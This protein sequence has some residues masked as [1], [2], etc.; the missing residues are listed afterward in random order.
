MGTDLDE[1]IGVFF[2]ARPMR[3][4][5][6]LLIGIVLAGPTTGRAALLDEAPPSH[7]FADTTAAFVPGE[8]IVMFRDDAGRHATRAAGAS[9]TRL[10]RDPG[11]GALDDLM[12]AHSV[13][14]M[15]RVFRG[16]EDGRGEL[17]ITARERAERWGRRRG[18]PLRSDVLERIPALEN[19]FL[20]QLDPEADV[21]AV[22]A[23]FAQDER[24]VFAHPN[25]LFRIL[26]EPLP[27]VA[28]VPDDP[29]LTRDGVHWS[30][31]AFGQAFPDLWGLRKIRAIEAWNRFD[32]DDSGD[33]GPQEIRPGEGVV[34]AV[35]DSGLDLDHPDVSLAVWTNPDEI[36]DNGIDDDSNGYVD[37]VHGW[38]FVGDDDSPTDENGHG[39][40]V[41]GTI[42]A[43]ADNALGIVGVAPWA[44]IMPIQGLSDRGSGTEADLAAA[45]DYAAAM[46]ARVIS[47][48]WGGNTSGAAMAAAFA[49]AHAFGALAVAAAGNANAS[50]ASLTPASIES[51][52]AVAA[53][54]HEDI[55]AGFSNFGRQ[56]DL[57]APGVRILS[58]NANGGDNRIVDEHPETSVDTDYMVISGTSM[59][60]PHVSGAAAVL[61]SQYPDESA[62]EIRGRLRAGAIDV[63]T[64]NPDFAT[65]LGS[66]RLDLSSS[67]EAVPAPVLWLDHLTVSGF[68]AASTAEISVHVTNYWQDVP[69]VHAELSTNSDDV[70]IVR[71]SADLGD[72][73]IATGASNES[74]PFLVEVGEE[75]VAGSRADFRLSLSGGGTLTQLEFSLSIAFFENVSESSRLPSSALVAWHVVMQDFTADGYP[76][77]GLSNGQS[78]VFFE[79][80]GNGRF[81]R[82]HTQ[83]GG[84]FPNYNQLFLDIDRDGDRDAFLSSLRSNGNRLLRNDGGG[85]WTNITGGSGLPDVRLV[86]MVATD[87][88]DDGWVDIVG[89]GAEPGRTIFLFRN[90]GDASFTDVWEE[91]GLDFRA[92]GSFPSIRMIDYDND[93]DSDLF[94]NALAGGRNRLALYRNDGSGHFENVTAAAFPGGVLDYLKALAAGDYDN[95]GDLDL[96]ANNA[97]PPPDVPTTLY[98][99]NGDGTF[100]DVTESA[101]DLA[102]TDILSLFWG[103]DFFDYDNDGDLDL[104]IT[105]ENSIA[106]E[107]TVPTQS[108]TLFR[109]NGDGTFS[110]VNEAA[111]GDAISPSV[112]TAAIGDYDGDGA[113]DI[114]APASTFLGV[115]PEAGGLLRNL[116]GARNNWIR[117]ELVGDTSNRDAYGAR[118]V[119][120]TR[121][122]SQIRE[123]HTAPVD[124]TGLHFGLG[125]APVIESIEV[126]WPSGIVQQ[127]HGIRVNRRLVIHECR[128]PET[129]PGRRRGQTCAR[130][131]PRSR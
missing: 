31:G 94:A 81:R 61:M 84:P 120:R 13:R 27:A 108:H 59:A 9:F 68:N 104:Y 10:L 54:D 101:G 45:V 12:R 77:V 98:R 92:L 17:R 116:I 41:A 122:G 130:G 23:E 49:N 118:V 72:I 107:D 69:D 73:P 44:Q 110:L 129:L 48:S 35:V 4:V 66:G 42:A 36:P 56:I 24:V 102:N 11:A 125:Q 86:A 55:R 109:N 43:H 57:T 5:N 83:S 121:G 15:R 22:A 30:E 1:R 3:V 2:G 111:F 124:P 21:E 40:H 82:S 85:A 119:V 16:L 62:D 91:S 99:N 20:L 32:T 103:S 50:V 75:A 51:V 88:D 76:D 93:G 34:V 127:L 115:D 131:R 80:L 8:L 65:T 67:L 90:N 29:Y 97:R 74:S 37:D 79:N 60:C 126:R 117:I 105:K 96:V 7:G 26:A 89:G 123:I 53:T 14:S 95:D 63:A 47:N 128:D 78:S 6:A 52:V 58:L 25:H 39:T 33:F 71:G 38:D 19:V 64:E 114:Y 87:L 46:G 100:T 18:R 113:L 106:P 28:F 112:G 70:T